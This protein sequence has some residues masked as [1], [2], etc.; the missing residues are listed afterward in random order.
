MK[1]S[2]ELGTEADE[3]HSGAVLVHG[4]VYISVC[5]FGLLCTRG[6]NVECGKRTLER[7]MLSSPGIPARGA[8]LLL[9]FTLKLSVIQK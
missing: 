3:L 4:F 2:A 6:S 5:V 1:S 8:K 7:K 9:T